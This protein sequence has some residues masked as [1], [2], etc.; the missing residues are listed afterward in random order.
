VQRLW[1]LLFLFILIFGVAF[2]AIAIFARADGWWLPEQ[3][4]TYAAKIDFLFNLI[5]VLTGVTFVLT[6]GAL[7]WFLYKYAAEPGRKGKFIHGHHRTEVVWTAVPALILVGVAVSQIPA[8]RQ[9]KMDP[10]LREHKPL[11]QIVARQ[12]E[13][14]FRYAGL[15]GEPGVAGVDDDHNGKLDDWG[16]WGYP[17]SDDV[18]TV[19]ELHIPAD[20]D[21][22]FHLRSLDVLHSFFVPEFRVKQDAVPGLVI[23]IW[24]HVKPDHK[25]SDYDLI[26]AELC[27]WGHYKMRG[28]VIV[29]DS[30]QQFEAK[31]ADLHKQQIASGSTVS[32][33]AEAP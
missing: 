18:E 24:F 16:E 14:R 28:R 7:V 31:L 1:S 9:I 8:W 32:E 15:D 12:F 2:F 21:L 13:W 27:G 22:V 10:K 20:E 11:A 4:P 23:P 29:Y 30:R 3:A 33:T 6:E 17:G 26:C 25:R 19:N 5:L